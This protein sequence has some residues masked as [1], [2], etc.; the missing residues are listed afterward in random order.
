MFLYAVVGVLQV[1]L[2]S[3]VAVAL[4]SVTAFMAIDLALAS[5]ALVPVIL[6]IVGST[7]GGVDPLLLIAS[8]VMLMGAIM[9]VGSALVEY[10]HA[11]LH[12]GLMPLPPVYSIT[13]SIMFLAGW[14]L[15]SAFLVTRIRGPWQRWPPCYW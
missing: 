1:I 8:L 14:L 13:A 3:V 2:L 4:H 10:I 15:T 9:N 5:L 12:A 7:V 6:L 11:A